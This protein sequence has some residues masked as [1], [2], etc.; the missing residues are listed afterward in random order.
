MEAWGMHMYRPLSIPADRDV[1][2]WALN[3]DHEGKEETT[4]SMSA[5]WPGVKQFRL[6]QDQ[7]SV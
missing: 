5:A 6:L 2:A 4:V 3:T 7:S 1:G